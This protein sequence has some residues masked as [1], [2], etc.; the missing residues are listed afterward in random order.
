VTKPSISAGTI[1]TYIACVLLGCGGIAAGV[2]KVAALNEMGERLKWRPPAQVTLRT[3]EGRFEQD[4]LTTA[5]AADTGSRR[6]T[7]G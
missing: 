3:V 2:M 6:P 5:T 4:T 7:V 1:A